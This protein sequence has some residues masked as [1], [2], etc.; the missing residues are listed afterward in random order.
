MFASSSQ[1][2]AKAGKHFGEHPAK[3]IISLEYTTPLASHSRKI[4]EDIGAQVQEFLWLLFAVA[5]PP[6][7]EALTCLCAQIRG[8]YLE[9]AFLDFP[10]INLSVFLEHAWL[11]ASFRTLK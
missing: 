7:V 5:K 11:C 2:V 8:K 1:L 6:E 9:D 10:R 3:G 4:W